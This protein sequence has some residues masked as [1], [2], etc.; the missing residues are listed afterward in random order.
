MRRKLFPGRRITRLPELPW[1]S[2]VFI[3]FLTKLGEHLT[4]ETDSWPGRRV[5]HEPGHSFSM[6]GSLL[7]GSTL[8]PHKHFDYPRRATQSR[9][10]SR[11]KGGWHSWLVRGLWCG[12]S[13]V[14]SLMIDLKFFS[15]LSRVID[16]RYGSF[17]FYQFLAREQGSSIFSYKSLLK[18]TRLRGWPF[19]PGQRFSNGA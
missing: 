1:A 5:T 8:S 3:H 15:Y 7:A 9:R 17:T 14:P 4:W 18:M 19:F 16:V 13:R 12:M 6:V 11:T 10:V 2:K